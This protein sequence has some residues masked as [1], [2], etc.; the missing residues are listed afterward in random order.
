[1]HTYTGF[2]HP[3]S[4][5]RSSPE[6]RI[7]HRIRRCSDCTRTSY[8][9]QNWRRGKCQVGSRRGRGRR[10]GRSP[11]GAARW[12]LTDIVHLPTLCYGQHRT[13]TTPRLMMPETLTHSWLVFAAGRCLDLRSEVQP[14]THPP[15]AN[16][17]DGTDPQ[18]G[19]MIPPGT[20]CTDCNH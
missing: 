18:T 11:P 4:P 17:Y 6:E 3:C 20:C 15:T 16:H 19:L 1:M 13:K 7:R 8:S 12:T 9:C 5:I 14:A 2:A 10:R